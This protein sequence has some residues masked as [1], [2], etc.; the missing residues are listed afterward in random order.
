MPR[1]P[2]TRRATN[3]PQPK[4]A[5]ATR[6]PAQ[7]EQ[8]GESASET[9]TKTSTDRH[10]RVLRYIENGRGLSS[11]TRNSRVRRHGPLDRERMEMDLEQ[12]LL[13]LTQG[14]I[15]DKVEDTFGPNP[16]TSLR[17]RHD[18]GTV[19]ELACDGKRCVHCGPRKEL[20]IRLQMD[21]IGHFGYIKRYRTRSELNKS[22]ER[23]RQQAKRA[24]DR[25]MLY[26]S[27]GDETLGWILVSNYQLEDEQNR[28]DI[29]DWYDRIIGQWHHSVQRMRRSRALGRV[30][31]LTYKRKAKSVHGSSWSF[32]RGDVDT[33]PWREPLS[34]EEKFAVWIGKRDVEKTDLVKKLLHRGG[35]W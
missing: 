21:S 7:T 28:T 8:V 3:Q 10:T 9:A 32:V 26:Q 22:I 20:T 14:I 2:L 24:D 4:H 31:R 15:H 30:S 34:E 23:I 27:V 5:S 35:E 6:I 1:P 17:L 18:D 11:S 25:D 16:C 13:H 29:R 12:A 33:E 19:I